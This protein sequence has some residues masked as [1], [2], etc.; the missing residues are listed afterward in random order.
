M[1]RT[2]N[3]ISSFSGQRVNVVPGYEFGT[4]TGYVALSKNWGNRWALMDASDPER[5]DRQLVLPRGAQIHSTGIRIG[6]GVKCAGFGN[7]HL[8]LINPLT[9]SPISLATTASNLCNIDSAAA[10]DD[11]PNRII[12]L[13]NAISDVAVAR[14]EFY[15]DPGITTPNPLT[16]INTLNS[17]GTVGNYGLSDNLLASFPSGFKL[18]INFRTGPTAASP[19]VTLGTFDAGL[20]QQ[21]PEPNKDFA[22]KAYILVDIGYWIR[23]PEVSSDDDLGLNWERIFKYIN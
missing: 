8:G 22:N 16:E 12:R 18:E 11:E 2:G 21:T 13:N 7:L 15:P 14:S 6:F 23:S 4:L 19:L 9:N 10:T 5:T 3:G 17:V 20:K 1:I